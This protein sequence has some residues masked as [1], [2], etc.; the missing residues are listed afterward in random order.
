L[1]RSLDA[2]F[3]PSSVAVIG[4][5]RHPGSI[6]SEILHKLLAGGFTGAVFPVN[7]HAESVHS[8]KC[9]PSVTEIPDPV[10]LAVVVVPRDLVAGVVEQCRKKKV[11]GLV[12]ITAGF[13]EV[14]RRGAALEARIR[15]RVRDAGMR[16]IGPNCMG[17][18]NTEPDVRLNATF[19]ATAPIRGSAGF[20]SQ[21]GALGEIILANARQ[22][23]LGIS[24]FASV[25]NKADVSGNDLLVYWEDDPS[26]A[27]ILMYLESFGN[28]KK[29]TQLAQ[30]VTRK[31]PIIA[32]KSGRTEA[33]ARAA[34][35]HTGALAGADVAS[36]TLFDQC[37]VLRVSTIEEMF[38][39]ATAFTTQPL[40]R[41]NRVAILTNAGGP[42]IMA[43]DA[44]V[45]LGLT[46]ASLTQKT[47]QH[48]KR[49]LP[50]E[51]SVAN[52]VDLIAS[53]DAQRYEVGL[54]ALLADPAVDG[55]IVL[56]VTPTMI[57][58]Q[59]VAE[60]IV[61]VSRGSKKPVLTC[62][63]GKDRGAE[64]VET[65]RENSVPVYPFP[66]NAAQ[67]M[68]ALDRYRRIRERP[69]GKMVRFR[70]RSERVASLLRA[71]GRQQRTH[72]SWEEADRV[73][74]A[75]GIPRPPGR[76][77]TGAADAIGAAL[78]IGYPV[79][80]K[81]ALAGFAHKTEVKGVRVDLRNGD[82][83]GRAYGEM[84]ARFGRKG[85][86]VLIQR[87]IRGGREVI[88]GSFQDR[89]FGTLLMF[90]LGG[91]FVEAM[92]DVTFRIHPITDRDAE[93]MIASIRGYPLLEGFRGE[94][95]VDRKLLQEMLLRLSQLLSDFP[96]I[97][98]V[99]INPFI[100]GSSRSDSFAVDARIALAAS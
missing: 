84:A 49:R 77:V 93:E 85:L 7:P 46:L 19:A 4:A 43:T 68:A 71:A 39:L 57:N 98:Q 59:R 28:P 23:S 60:T 86:P 34:F 62:F 44:A 9:Y 20:M 48:L 61:R 22:I 18:I 83:V 80:M 3:R 12:V 90:G 26:V 35:S 37:G 13:R 99:D 75:Y 78:E 73:L 87:M 74:A 88:L 38:T 56:F 2:I 14:G 51:C 42:A 72:L 97:E 45:N 92:K 32:V 100:A 40:P 55:A 6:G 94:P 70:V 64:G 82:E 10:D 69:R 79:V 30:R 25:G 63:M 91:I 16:M 50:P 81:V 52:P 53:A 58:A 67:A 89:Q 54:R 24:M 36:S 65:L 27:V 31:K 1:K 33:G 41:G 8:I 95:G 17:V 15:D 5:S 96:A 66:E 21:S 76:V 11:R 29:F 47:R